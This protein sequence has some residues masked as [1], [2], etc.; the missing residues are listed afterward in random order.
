MDGISI[1]LWLITL[2]I[3][4]ILFANFSEMRRKI[5]WMDQKLK[6]M[7]NELE[8]LRQSTPLQKSKRKKTNSQID[9]S[10][11]K[12]PDNQKENKI[13]I[14]KDSQKTLSLK[15]EETENVISYKPSPWKRQFSEF[16]KLFME[17]YTGFL[18]GG[19]LILGLVFLAIF[20]ALK[21]E[22]LGRIMILFTGVFL[23]LFIS[24]IL[25]KKSFLKNS[26]LWIQSTAGALFLFTS[27]AAGH[28]PGLIIFHSSTLIYISLGT[29]ILFIIIS[30]YFSRSMTIFTLHYIYSLLALGAT[31]DSVMTYYA[32]IAIAFFSLIAIS[33]IKE[34][35]RERWTLPLFIGA[36]LIYMFFWYHPVPLETTQW[37]ETSWII[38]TLSAWIGVSPI[39]WLNS[40]RK[41]SSFNTSRALTWAYMM[42]TLILGAKYMHASWIGFVIL[43]S[44]SF[45]F[46]QISR[47]T[48]NYANVNR[49]IDYIYLFIFLS[50]SIFQYHN[51]KLNDPFRYLMLITITSFFILPLKDMPQKHQKTGLYFSKIISFLRFLF[52]LMFL[53]LMIDETNPPSVNIL[54]AVITSVVLI[55]GIYMRNRYEINDLSSKFWFSKIF[56]ES[57]QP[58][59]SVD[60][61]SLAFTLYSQLFATLSF[62]WSTISVILTISAFSISLLLLEKNIIKIHEKN[63]WII[64]HNISG[65]LGISI[66]FLY[67]TIWYHFHEDIPQYETLF[68]SFFY[69]IPLLFFFYKMIQKKNPA[70]WVLISVL[71]LHS[72]FTIFALSMHYMT[73]LYFLFLFTLII[74]GGIFWSTQ[75]KNAWLLDL[76]VF[77]SY[78]LLTFFLFHWILDNEHLYTIEI[79]FLGAFLAFISFHFVQFFEKTKIKELFLELSFFIL[80][81]IILWDISSIYQIPAFAGL[82]ILS[83]IIGIYYQSAYRFTVYSLLFHIVTVTFV[84][85]F[86]KMNH[87]YTG[88]GLSIQLIYII[89]FHKGNGLKL[90][91]EKISIK[92][93]TMYNFLI[94]WQNGIVY[95]AFFISI[96][97]FIWMNM[98]NTFLTLIWAVEAFFIFIL[99]LYLKEAHFRYM[100][101]GVFFFCIL[102]LVFW[103]LSESHTLTR[104]LVFIGTGALLLIMNII[105]QKFKDMDSQPPNMHP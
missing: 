78:I 92:P 84:L 32:S 47:N 97:I 31:K 77:A 20:G 95:Y 44:L 39:L 21:M 65:G 28:I 98:E 104:A 73:S 105:Y 13:M 42:I 1:V 70:A 53:V 62:Y 86:S 24:W 38:L 40:I 2:I 55:F 100:A 46:I 14:G 17:N 85:F 36:G 79:G 3:F 64:T 69:F 93:G 26:S 51:P 9:E 67:P 30:G 56:P 19:I 76:F 7:Y 35:K 48:E 59:L 50:L 5:Q 89:L 101:S 87:F 54:L 88:I 68:I 60:S 80:V 90:L 82:S 43:A 16:E 74:T 83:Y 12:S 33:R 61:I 8:T 34:N 66:I 4:I 49:L 58:Y 29:G 18:G 10:L 71:T 72:V 37:K 63:H 11:S 91:H 15:S 57:I 75:K 52:S 103:D 27:F 99:G 25:K 23:L 96:G 41:I 102:R 6:S 94:K 22:A 45:L 81:K